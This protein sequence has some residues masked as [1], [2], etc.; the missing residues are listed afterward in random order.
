MKESCINP[1][2]G[3]S[4]SRS[5]EDALRSHFNV[6]NDLEKKIDELIELPKMSC[7]YSECGEVTTGNR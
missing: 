7:G 5:V 2:G 1:P 6:L 3:Y 4:S